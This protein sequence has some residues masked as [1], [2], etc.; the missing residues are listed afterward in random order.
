MRTRKW[1][2]QGRC[3]QAPGLLRKGAWGG[4]GGQ[5]LGHGWAGGAQDRAEALGAQGASEIAWLQA[6]GRPQ[7]CA[8]QAA[9]AKQCS[10]PWVE[11]KRS[12]GLS[13]RGTLSPTACAGEA[14]AQ[15]ALR[16]VRR[17]A[18]HP[19]RHC[20]R[21]GVAIGGARAVKAGCRRAYRHRRHWG[22][23]CT[24][25]VPAVPLRS[26]AA[27]WGGAGAPCPG[28]GRAPGQPHIAP[29]GSGKLP[30]GSGPL[31]GQLGH[32]RP[33]PGAQGRCHLLQ[34]P[35]RASIA[36]AIASPCRNVHPLH[37]PQPTPEPMWPRHLEGPRP[38]QRGGGRQPLRRR[39]M[40]P[41]ASTPGVALCWQPGRPKALRSGQPSG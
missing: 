14:Q 13:C 32:G 40:A 11:R 28:H 12:L 29:R 26:L 7:A 34:L 10:R 39:T 4:V 35:A 41:L 23:G 6:C 36:L 18:L 20:H 30:G 38:C 27:R 31:P 17:M 3:V 37:R 19:W 15:A 8:G 24:L 25:C 16:R 9:P 22:R 21:R 1:P 33:P 5:L 2:T